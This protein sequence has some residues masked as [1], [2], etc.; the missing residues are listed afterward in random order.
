MKHKETINKECKKI[1][2]F[3]MLTNMN[4][5]MKHYIS[6]KFIL[7]SRFKMMRPLAENIEIFRDIESKQTKIAF[8]C[9]YNNKKITKIWQKLN[10]QFFLQN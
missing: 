4:N 1:M 5:L 10:E 7:Y 6:R 2:N 9:S 3:Q 8:C